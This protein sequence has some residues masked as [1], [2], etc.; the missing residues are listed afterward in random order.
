MLFEKVCKQ[1][2]LVQSNKKR[3]FFFS[4]RDISV[5]FRYTII[6]PFLRSSMSPVIQYLLLVRYDVRVWACAYVE[7][8]S[9]G[10]CFPASFVCSPRPRHTSQQRLG[11]LLFLILLFRKQLFTPRPRYD[12]R[13]WLYVG[14][15]ILFETNI[16]S[17]AT[18][19]EG[20]VRYCV[21]WKSLKAETFKILVLRLVRSNILYE[22]L[23]IIWK[24]Q[25]SYCMLSDEKLKLFIRK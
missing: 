15:L 20:T 22:Y 25:S 16:K 6:H 10:R 23:C 3:V 4:T 12:L 18:H 1:K 2:T 19:E 5:T 8:R 24:P 11:L 9:P 17:N 7:H 21:G 13:L 14:L